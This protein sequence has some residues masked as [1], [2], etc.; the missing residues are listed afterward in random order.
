MVIPYAFE[1]V[2]VLEA[3]QDEKC[4]R[5]TACRQC[6]SLSL[7]F[8]VRVVR[9]FELADRDYGAF[10]AI[11]V[12][13]QVIERMNMDEVTI[14]YERLVHHPCQ[15]RPAPMTRST[16]ELIRVSTFMSKSCHDPEIPNGSSRKSGEFQTRDIR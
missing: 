7:V 4:P 1:L 5:S 2:S 3:V 8:R 14:A 9:P 16:N 13:K 11:E 10:H 12:M 6:S 15:P